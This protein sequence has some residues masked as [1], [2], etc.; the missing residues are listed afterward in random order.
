MPRAVSPSA[1]D[2]WPR[3]SIPRASRSLSSNRRAMANDLVGQPE[4]GPGLA[5]AERFEEHRD[6]QIATSPRIQP[7]RRRR[8]GWRERTSHQPA[9]CRRGAAGPWPA[10]PR[11]VPRGRD[12]RD[13]RIRD[14]PAPTPGCSRHPGR[15]NRRPPPGVR[16]RQPPASRRQRAVRRHRPTPVGRRPRALC[17]LRR[18]RT[19]VLLTLASPRSGRRRPRRR[20]AALGGVL[21]DRRRSATHAARR[22][23]PLRRSESWC[24]LLTSFVADSGIPRLRRW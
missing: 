17:R 7:L 14:M 1:S 4:G 10:T 12:R 20:V 24:M 13:E 2:A 16:S 19:T 8:A 6:Q 11:T 5:P 15:L 23:T 22:R 3:P 18:S 21:I 9:P